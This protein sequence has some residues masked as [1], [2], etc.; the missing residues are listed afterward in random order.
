MAVVLYEKKGRT[1]Y[2]IIDRPEKRNAINYDVR[3]GLSDA[4]EKTNNDPDVYSVIISGGDTVF[5]VGQDLEEIRRYRQRELVED[6]PLCDKA[7]DTY[8]KKPVIAAIN[9][10]CLGIY[11]TTR[12]NGS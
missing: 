11:S 9:G 5:S 4:W 12:V 2:V 3:Q 8:I 10:Y 7:Y 6:L 1:A